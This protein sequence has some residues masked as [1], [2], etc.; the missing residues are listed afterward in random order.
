M[1][2]T[3]NFEG[4]IFA[5]SLESIHRAP[6]SH[7]PV[8]GLRGPKKALIIPYLRFQFLSYLAGLMPGW[9]PDQFLGDILNASQKAEEMAEVQDE[10]YFRREGGGN[11]DPSFPV[12][13][14][15][16]HIGVPGQACF[17]QLQ[18]QPAMPFRQ[19]GS[20]GKSGSGLKGVGFR[21]ASI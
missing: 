3:G 8:W 11:F 10:I 2:R 19:K 1:C 6:A 13:H 5:A 18:S 14:K 12:P 7:R 4:F 16:P 17:F 21:R 20:A 15:T 9:K